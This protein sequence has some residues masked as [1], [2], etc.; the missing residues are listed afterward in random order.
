MPQ[1]NKARKAEAEGQIVVA[2]IAQKVNTKQLTP[3][4]R[5]FCELVADYTDSRSMEAKTQECGYKSTR[6]GYTLCHKPEIAA[7]IDRLVEI[8]LRA[9]RQKRG[10]VLAALYN[11]AQTCESTRDANQAAELFLKWTGD[12]GDGANKT[13][14][15]VNNGT[16]QERDE[17]L[18]EAI[19]R[20]RG[21]NGNR[22]K[23]EA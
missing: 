18:A 6:Y 8:N 7:E 16:P 23:N 10:T 21:G 12:I 22:A 15:N 17:E 3:Q 19:R 9:L 14:V 2:V 5:A 1:G 13:Y 20:L 11:R 4:E